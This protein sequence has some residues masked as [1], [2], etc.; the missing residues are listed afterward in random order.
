MLGMD[1]AEMKMKWRTEQRYEIR[2]HIRTIF[3]FN[4]LL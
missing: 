2:T 3:D 1:A 4:R